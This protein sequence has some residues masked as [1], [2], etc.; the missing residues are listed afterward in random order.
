MATLIAQ[1][2]ESIAS[3]PN[4]S[5][6][7]PP[8]LTSW[9]GVM[10]VVLVVNLV[11][12]SLLGSG[13]ACSPIGLRSNS[14]PH[15]DTAFLLGNSGSASL[16]HDT[17]CKNLC[18]AHMRSLIASPD[19]LASCHSLCHAD[20]ADMPYEGPRNTSAYPH[21]HH[22]PVIAAFWI[23]ALNV[24]SQTARVQLVLLL[25]LIFGVSLGICLACC[26]FMV[27][28]HFILPSQ[29]SEPGRLCRKLLTG[30]T[31]IEP[32]QY[33]DN[34]YIPGTVASGFVLTSFMVMNLIHFLDSILSRQPMVHIGLSKT[35]MTAL[36]YLLYTSE[37]DITP[38]NDRSPC[39]D[40]Q[41]FPPGTS[42][43]FAT[44]V[45]SYTVN[46]SQT[47]THAVKSETA[48]IAG[49][50]MIR[51]FRRPVPPLSSIPYNLAMNNASM[52]VEC[53]RS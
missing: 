45:I 13:L 42:G 46:G 22:P 50:M 24:N 23:A 47:G 2:S 36:A 38:E 12:T 3:A 25:T 26:G 6:L 14:S 52:V 37:R 40:A 33:F 9:E 48:Q 29:D 51:Y 53:L 39:T 10:L 20:D 4:L 30:K 1:T 34:S 21:A 35:Y 18:V 5:T 41:S 11:W 43:F 19:Y 49:T 7:Q 27:P 15:L 31:A 44:D 32:R 8:T 28:K 16:F 17:T